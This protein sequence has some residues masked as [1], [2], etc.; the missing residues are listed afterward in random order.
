MV[1]G[2]IGLLAIVNTGSP[3]ARQ[4]L[5]LRAL[6]RLA[7]MSLDTMQTLVSLPDI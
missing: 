2:V 3:S 5:L 6:R 1:A 4:L 7:A